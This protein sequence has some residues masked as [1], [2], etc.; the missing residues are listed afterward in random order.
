MPTTAGT[1]L[2]PVK[3]RRTLCEKYNT[4]IVRLKTLQLN[5]LQRVFSDWPRCFDPLN[6]QVLQFFSTFHTV[7][8]FVLLLLVAIGL[9]WW[10]FGHELSKVIERPS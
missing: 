2:L 10:R 4:I 5:G 7:W 9:F 6:F 3:P 1:L 8:R